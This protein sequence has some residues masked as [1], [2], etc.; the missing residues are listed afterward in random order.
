MEK[1]NKFLLFFKRYGYYFIAG[2]LVVA[3]GLTLIL[4]TRQPQLNIVPDDSDVV[5]VGAQ[6]ISFTLPMK[7]LTVL[8]AFSDSELQYNKTMKEWSAHKAYDFTANDLSVYAVAS[9]TVS[10]VTE[11]YLM[12]TII[13]IT[14]KDGFKS[15]YSSLENDT[16]VK[17]GDQVEKGQKIGSASST[18][19]SESSEE[20]HLHF[21][22]L[23]DDAKV[24]PS[25][26]L[27]LSNK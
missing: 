19:S 5:D 18:A 11:S 16:L 25:N 13:E 15:V 9:G 22:L 24:D 21:E 12:G 27:N 7:D 4:A 3:I 10:D 26:Y 23:K 20:K 6:P 17:E 14:H 1:Q 2:I 8:K